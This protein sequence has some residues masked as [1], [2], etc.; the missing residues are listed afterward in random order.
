MIPT[1]TYILDGEK[2]RFRITLEP[3]LHAC[4]PPTASYHAFNGS[5]WEPVALRSFP[6]DVWP[7][8]HET[9]DAASMLWGKPLYVARTYSCGCWEVWRYSGFGG[10]YLQDAGTSLE[11]MAG[12]EEKGL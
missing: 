1:Q 2:P 9:F 4:D 5:A 7:W 6:E 11:C 12:Q 10:K 3:G 8:V